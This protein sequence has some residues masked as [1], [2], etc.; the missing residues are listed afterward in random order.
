MKN[1]SVYCLLLLTSFLLTGCFEIKEEIKLKKDGTGRVTLTVNLSESKVNIANYLK[2]GEYNGIK[3]P[4]IREIE[5]EFQNVKKA[6]ATAPGISN[7]SGNSDYREYVFTI[8][9]DFASVEDLNESINHVI[10][11]MNRTPFETIQVDNYDLTSKSFRRYFNYPV[12]LIDFEQL[13]TI[14]QFALESARMVTEYS[15]DEPIRTFTNEDAKLAPSKKTITL[16][17]SLGQVIQGN[18][19]PANSV[20]FSF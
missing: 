7:V 3:I 15:F 12:T 9:G 13:P 8:S 10:R 16:V 20:I 18:A 19:T 11:K 17:N 2:M 4:D 6:F 14:Y 1:F 5:A